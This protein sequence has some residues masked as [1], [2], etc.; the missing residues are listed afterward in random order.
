MSI[1]LIIL[2]GIIVYIVA[3]GLTKSCYSDINEL[4][5][6]KYKLI[7]TEKVTTIFA[8]VWPITFPW[9]LIMF[10]GYIGMYF[11]LMF[12]QT[13]HYVIGPFLPEKWQ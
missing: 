12:V 1:L 5:F 7:M 6:F 4:R 13:I 2:I 11:V 9:L 8:L 3:A 10:V